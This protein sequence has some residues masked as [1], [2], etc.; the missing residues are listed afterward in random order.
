M[1]NHRECVTTWRNNV[2]AMEEYEK[3]INGDSLKQLGY[4]TTYNPL[5]PKNLIFTAILG[6]KVSNAN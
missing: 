4:T 1:K 2:T 5:D 3:Q 6:W